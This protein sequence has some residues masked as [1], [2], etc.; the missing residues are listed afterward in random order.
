MIE[1][2]YPIFPHQI[3][4][5]DGETVK[6][7]IRLPDGEKTVCEKNKYSWIRPFQFG[8]FL[9]S[10]DLAQGIGEIHHSRFIRG[11]ARHIRTSVLGLLMDKNIHIGT[12]FV[13]EY[14]A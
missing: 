2:Y 14:S 8:Y 9:S 5:V 13:K 10:Y 12:L 3:A 4:I 11:R 1:N 6:R 7:T